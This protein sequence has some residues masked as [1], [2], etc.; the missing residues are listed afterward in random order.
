MLHQKVFQA[1]CRSDICSIT[2]LPGEIHPTANCPWSHRPT[3]GQCALN[4]K[5]PT[6]VSKSNAYKSLLNFGSRYALQPGS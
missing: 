3:S 2:N 1:I 6:D 5:G 4:G